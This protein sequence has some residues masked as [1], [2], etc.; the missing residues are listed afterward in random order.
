MLCWLLVASLGGFDGA[1]DGAFF[2]R[3]CAP[4]LHGGRVCAPFGAFAAAA[5]C[6]WLSWTRGLNLTKSYHIACIFVKRAA[7]T[8]VNLG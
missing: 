5:R 6:C 4:Q 7:S 3:V 1:E 8:A 2:G